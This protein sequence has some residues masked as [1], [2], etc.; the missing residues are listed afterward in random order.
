M[1]QNLNKYF[2]KSYPSGLKA[3]KMVLNII[4]LREIKIKTRYHFTH[5]RMVI[6]RLTPPI[7]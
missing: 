5:T 4:I 3:Y 7:T 1:M 2:L 6:K